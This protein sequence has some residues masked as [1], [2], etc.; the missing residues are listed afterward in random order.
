[1]WC[2]TRYCGG[3]R[4]EKRTVFYHVDFNILRH[5]YEKNSHASGL[6]NSI[7]HTLNLSGIFMVG[8]NFIW[9]NKQSCPTLEKLDR[10]LMPTSWEDVFPMV[11]VKNWF[12]S[13]LTIMHSSITV[14]MCN[15]LGL[16]AEVLNLIWTG[17]NMNFSFPWSQNFGLNMLLVWI[18][19]I[20]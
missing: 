2:E 14:V 4:C 10:V 7:I 19:L 8:G 9:S 11:H 1:M 17:S 16:G 6:F 13:S 5:C 15:L 20:F 18:L 12:E 3:F